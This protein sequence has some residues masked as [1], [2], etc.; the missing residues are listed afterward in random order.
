MKVLKK[1]FRKKESKRIVRK[2]IRKI[3][4]KKPLGRWCEYYEGRLPYPIEC[5]SNKEVPLCIDRPNC[6]KCNRHLE[7]ADW[8]GGMWEKVNQAVQNGEDLTDMDSPCH[9]KYKGD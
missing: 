1:K 8:K 9:N 4:R 5:Q 7:W 2:I 3:V 6:K